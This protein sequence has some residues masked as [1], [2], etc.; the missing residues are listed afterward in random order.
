MY[1]FVDL[2]KS[3]FINTSAEK[4][5]YV[6][7]LGR[8]KKGIISLIFFAILTLHEN[9][10]VPGEARTIFKKKK[11][12]LVTHFAITNKIYTPKR[13]LFLCF[14]S[15]RFKGTFEFEN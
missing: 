10:V 3:K 13:A 6:V 15:S 7:R 5:T 4:V 1:L 2:Q 9:Y 8:D 11:S 12:Y 14:W